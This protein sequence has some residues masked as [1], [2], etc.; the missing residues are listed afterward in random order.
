LRAGDWS[1]D[2][3]QS[4]WNV[5]FDVR[6]HVEPG[7]AQV[8]EAARPWNMTAFDHR[9]PLFVSPQQNDFSTCNPAHPLSK[10]VSSQLI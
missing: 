2:N 8:R 4:D 9:R 5:Y 3:Y 10:S 7:T 1:G 6:P